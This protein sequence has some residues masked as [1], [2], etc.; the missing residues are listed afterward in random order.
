M[1]VELSVLKFFCKYREK[2]AKYNSYVNSMPNMEREIKMILNLIRNF[3]EKYDVD[4]VEQG[5]LAPFFDFQYPQH[6]DREIFFK[7]IDTMWETDTHDMVI[8]DLLEQMME[9]HHAIKIINKLLPTM[10]GVRYDTV[11][12]VKNDVDEFVQKMANPPE[13]EET[14]I[15]CMLTTAELAEDLKQIGW[16]THLNG[17]ND[18]IGGVKEDSVGCVAAY[19]DS[20]KTSFAMKMCAK[21]SEQIPDEDNIL[22][23]GN[24]ENSKR[25]CNR[26][27]QAYCEVNRDLIIE[28]PDR[29]EDQKMKMGYGKVK[30]VSGVDFGHQLIKL[31]E[32]WKPKIAFVDLASDLIVEFDKKY[33]GVNYLEQLFKWYRQVATK[34]RVAL[35]LVVQG[36]GDA[37]NKKWLDLI[38]L[39]GARVAIQRSLDWCIG[40][41]RMQKDEAK[42]LVRY[43]NISKNKQ[44]YGRQHKFL[45]RFEA[46]VNTWRDM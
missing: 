40:I 43:I 38:D 23:A 13:T 45:A 34:Y 28:D 32:E 27:T 7:I 10:E 8:E 26:L 20:G 16:Q 35:I 19:V 31:L 46:E 17:I 18:T 21:L 24:E 2:Y 4:H 33:E 14:L 15:P 25:L 5:N 39:Y 22:Y 1:S 9:K 41:G 6:K 30:V 44:Y 37:H 42:E 29:F 12:H 36:V 3:Y 11:A